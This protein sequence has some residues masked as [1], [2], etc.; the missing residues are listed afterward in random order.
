V[1]AA[2]QSDPSF[3]HFYY[4]ATV[5]VE[6]EWGDERLRDLRWFF[7]SLPEVRRLWSQGKL[8]TG[9]VPASD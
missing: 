4:S 9:G 1:L 8:V 6:K 5:R 7:D 2:Q 3:V